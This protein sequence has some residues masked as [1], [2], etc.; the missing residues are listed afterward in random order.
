MM[1]T[2]TITI[3]ITIKIKI[4]SLHNGP[5][6]KRKGIDGFVS[7]LSISLAEQEKTLFE[8]INL[9]RFNQGF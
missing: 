3:T 5:Y 7:L 8:Q 6:I 2:I 4:G 9:C 1:K